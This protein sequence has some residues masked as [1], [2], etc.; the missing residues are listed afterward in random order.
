MPFQY[1]I[2]RYVWLDMINSRNELQWKYINIIIIF[3]L[4]IW[5]LWPVHYILYNNFNKNRR[6]KIKG[7]LLWDVWP[8]LIKFLLSNI[9][10][11]CV[12]MYSCEYGDFKCIL[13]HNNLMGVI[14]KI[15]IIIFKA[16]QIQNRRR[17]PVVPY[18][19][20]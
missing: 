18:Y 20:L 1:F 15:S 3:F 13:N 6:I 11:V 12:H 9:H 8:I 14:Y 10:V 17:S 5:Y 2:G 7:I 4:C 19:N 16:V